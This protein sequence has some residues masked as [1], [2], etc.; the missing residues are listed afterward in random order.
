MAAP[1]ARLQSHGWTEQST[2]QS[3]TTLVVATIA[4]GDRASDRRLEALGQT[5]AI[6][7]IRAYR[8]APG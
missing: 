5:S 2:Q 8:S 1:S 6:R 7:K 3:M 4:I